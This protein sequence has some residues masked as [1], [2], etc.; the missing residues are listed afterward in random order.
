[1]IPLKDQEFV[2]AKFG[3]ELVGSVKIDFFTERDLAISVPNRKPCELCK[4]T[5]QM[6]R[7]LAALS[8]VI[9]LRTHIFD[10]DAAARDEFGIERI[11]AIVLRGPGGATF[12][13][14]GMPGGTEFPAF[15]ESIVDISRL[16]VLLSPESVAQ[17]TT[18]QDDV[19]VRVFV[20][21]TC[22]YCPEMMRAAYQLSIA[23]QHVKSEVI[24]VNEFPELA[25]RYSVTAVPITVINDALAI[26]GAVPEQ[27]LVEQVVKAAASPAAP[28]L[29]PASPAK[30]NQ[31]KRGEVR[32]SGLY[33]P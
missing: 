20:T 2:R 17:L 7:E 26:P 4:P 28:P 22:Q 13:F 11:P 19:S 3:Q 24:E 12:K 33:I 25:E 16:E 30:K 8:P 21:P 10:E 6:L 32:D 14:Y 27:V 15:V 1:M 31:P 23:N 9:S 29:G 18:V 5:G